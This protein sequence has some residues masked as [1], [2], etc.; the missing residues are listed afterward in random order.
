MIVGSHFLA[1]SAPNDAEL[2]DLRARLA[3]ELSRCPS[4]LPTPIGGSGSSYR[5]FT[6][7]ES[8][9]EL[10]AALSD[11]KGAVE[12]GPEATRTAF[13][14]PGHGADGG[15]VGSDLYDSLPRFRRHFDTCAKQLAAEIDLIAALRD[16]PPEHS[17]LVL[18][19]LE[20]A[21]AHTW[22]DWGVEPAAMIGH[23]LGEYAA[24]SLA[25]V[26]S[27]TDALAVIRQRT[28]LT[29]G[30]EDLPC[31]TRIRQ[32][33]LDAVARRSGRCARTCRAARRDLP[34]GCEGRLC[35]FQPHHG[36]ECRG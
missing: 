5:W 9:E 32:S 27:L 18:F 14:F 4:N 1:L 33:K 34:E 2:A 15:G 19:A 10:I 3:T 12:V 30:I 25:E 13:L 29:R 17:P 8:T 7:Y 24:A 23:S 31:Q 20:Y 21:L 36:F 22:L 11:G 16:P 6:V 28:R 35:S 26:F